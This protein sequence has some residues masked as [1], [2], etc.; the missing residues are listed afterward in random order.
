M[1]PE[2]PARTTAAPRKRRVRTT[3]LSR[4]APVP[5]PTRPFVPPGT[6]LTRRITRLRDH[7]HRHGRQTV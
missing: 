5:A 1:D 3:V 7:P 2:A 6:P 4:R